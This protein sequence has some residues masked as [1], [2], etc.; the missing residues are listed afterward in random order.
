MTRYTAT[1]GFAHDTPSV[2]GILLVNLGSPDAPTRAAVKR[3]LG[4]FLW[5]PRVVETPR[6]LWW[7]ILRLF[8]L[9]FRPARSARNYQKIW[10]DSGSPLVA[11][12]TRLAKALADRLTGRH[13]DA[14]R[15]ESAMRYGNPSIPDR[16][17]ALREAGARRLL[18]LPLYPQYSATTTASVF[19]AVADELKQWRWLPELRLV[20]GYPDDPAYTGALASSI[21]THWRT[22]ERGE[23]LIFSFHGIPQRYF[24]KGDPYH[25]Q[26]HKTA[27]LVAETL[28]LEPGQW[29]VAFQSRFG[30]EPWLAPYTDHVLGALAAEGVFSVDVVCPG[31]SMDCLE[32]LEEIDMQNR[33]IFLC[34]GGREFHYI[35]ALNDSTEHVDALERIIDGH[36][37]SWLDAGDAK[38]RRRATDLTRERAIAMGAER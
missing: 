16:L 7:L 30:R 26:C 3:Y 17:G 20:N 22:H 28:K 2:T 25:C 14:V 31:F 23:R 15:I 24:S 1:K 21:E 38:L 36:I 6:W 4:E 13:G 19:D 11:G 8:I 5:D 34:A 35:P 33:E 10:T 12:S 32:T 18:V 29:Q 27:R 37:C 9:N